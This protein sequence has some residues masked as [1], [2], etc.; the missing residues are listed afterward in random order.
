MIRGT[1]PA[2]AAAIQRI[3]GELD[4][5]VP[6]ANSERL[7]SIVDEATARVRLT[8]LLIAVAGAAALLLGVI[9]VYSVL[10]TPRRSEHGSSGSVSRSVPRRHAS[11]RWFSATA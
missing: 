6:A 5:R 1:R 2:D 10:H 7:G 8:M 11:V 4:R 9:G 3:V